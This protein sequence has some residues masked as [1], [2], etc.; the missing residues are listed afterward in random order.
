MRLNDDLEN[1][2]CEYQFVLLSLCIV[3]IAWLANILSIFSYFHTP[4]IILFILMLFGIIIFLSTKKGFSFNDIPRDVGVTI[5]FVII[6]SLFTSF[7]FHDTFY[8]GRDPGIYT[9]DAI[10]LSEHGTLYITSAINEYI[11]NHLSP[12]N[13]YNNTDTVITQFHFGYIS[14]LS[15]FSGIFGIGGIKFSNILFLFIGMMSLFFIGK[16]L[17]NS[18]V[19]IGT[20]IIYA[21]SYPL[22]WFS[23][24]TV[25]EIMFMALF[26]LGVLC[27]LYILRKKQPIFYISS[28]LSF[29]LLPFIRIEGSIIFGFYILFLTIISLYEYKVKTTTDIISSDV[30]SNYVYE[31][32]KN[33]LSKFTKHFSYLFLI[34]ITSIIILLLYYY[35]VTQTRYLG[36][37]DAAL[38][39]FSGADVSN[40]TIPV[41]L[42]NNAIRYH[43][44]DFIFSALSLYNLQLPLISI[45]ILFINSITSLNVVSK[46]QLLIIFFL[47]PGFLYLLTPFITLDQ[48]W[49]LRRY[50]ATTIPGAFLFFSILL[51]DFT[52]KR[53]LFSYFIVIF[54]I[55]NIVTS[56]PILFFSQNQGVVHQLSNIADQIGPNDLV[57]VDRYAAGDY[58]LADPLFFVYNKYALWWDADSIKQLNNV[59]DPSQFDHIYVLVNNPNTIDKNFPKADAQLIYNRSISLKELEITVNLKNV[60]GRTPDL[61]DMN[62]SIAK[63]LMRKPSNIKVSQPNLQLY[64]IRD[65]AGFNKSDYL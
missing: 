14:W 21:F 7:Y 51:Y 27:C 30:P 47:L 16:E 10:Y 53:N 56:M 32:T 62:Y 33:K 59:L 61:Y 52:K 41:S 35:F 5:I 26:W 18:Y 15:I 28:L 2:Q 36:V 34:L 48:P 43:F 49:F 3:C 22:I 50:V 11:A 63:S 65:Y 9:N 6:F 58:K 57:L 37:F 23:R 42:D 60:P 45:I 55:L 13:Y 12:G 25:T 19:G 64:L 38:K 17:R 39:H 24:Q 44:S 4:I 8:G 54:L 20:V 29:A 40:P 1:F 31:R 46:K